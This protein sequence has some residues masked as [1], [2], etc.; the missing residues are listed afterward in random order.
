MSPRTKKVIAVLVGAAFS[1]GLLYLMATFVDWRAFRD[2]LPP[3]VGGP[4]VLSGGIY[5]VTLAIR[6]VRF[7]VL[8]RW[9]SEARVPLLPSFDLVVVNNLLNHLMPLRAGELAFLSLARARHQVAVTDSAAV[10]L[11]ARIGDLTGLLA[12][13][14]VAALFITL[15]VEVKA[16]LFASA[17]VGVIALWRLD[18]FARWGQKL[19]AA[20]AGKLLPAAVA[21]RLDGV[22]AKMIAVAGRLEDR[23]VALFNFVVSLLIWA[24]NT[25]FFWTVM[26]L[27]EIP[28]S[29]AQVFIGGSGAAILPSLP[30]NAI[31]SLGTLEAG[32]TAGLTLVGL[33]MERATASGFVMHGTV[34]FVSV[35][36]GL[37]AGVRL[38]WALVRR[39]APSPDAAG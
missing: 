34:L 28:V 14:A 3:G 16:V 21:Q 10:L 18:L 22:W 1:A 23:R 25:V 6:A 33:D 32:W 7:T 9:L 29:F 38:W 31:G 4:L 30:I 36:V 27:L 39:K 20:A 8:F 12:G 5:I 13:M 15:A 2:G 19:A 26:T 24:T 35:V 17:L 11:V 37:Y